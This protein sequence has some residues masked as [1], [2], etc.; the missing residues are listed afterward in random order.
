MND[1]ARRYNI[2]G[3]L[4]PSSSS[5]KKK[6]RNKKNALAPLTNPIFPLTRTTTATDNPFID[7][8]VEFA[9][10]LRDLNVSHHLNVVHEFPHG[11]LDFGF[12]A[13]NVAEYN[14]EIINMML[15][16]LKQS[17]STSDAI[18]SESNH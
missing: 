18:A 11:F 6:K 7:D 4:F 13:A 14:I 8:N 1:L 2:G 9:R 12:A 10:R 17:A 5:T 16:I 15:N 3:P